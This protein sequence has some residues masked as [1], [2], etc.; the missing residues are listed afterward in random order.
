[1]PWSWSASQVAQVED[2]RIDGAP[3]GGQPR[4]GPRTAR[5]A[6]GRFDDG[7]RQFELVEQIAED[8]VAEDGLV[9]S[10]ATKGS[11]LMGIVADRADGLYNMR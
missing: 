4:A 1:L 7:K 2:G 8:A 3:G 11:F 10:T 5:P 6:L 9:D